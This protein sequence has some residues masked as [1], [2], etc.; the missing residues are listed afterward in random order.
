MRTIIKLLQKREI[1]TI[2]Q[3]RFLEKT[4]AKF[5]KHK[6][7]LAPPQG[8]K[9][10]VTKDIQIWSDPQT[11][12]IYEQQIKNWNEKQKSDMCP[13]GINEQQGK[14]IYYLKKGD[15]KVHYMSSKNGHSPELYLHCL[16][17][18]D[19]YI[20]IIHTGSIN[21]KGTYCINWSH[22]KFIE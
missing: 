15:Y 16:N 3:K 7:I 12:W 11:A 20:F 14:K 4:V 17:D 1:N 13:I 5:Q 10:K 22:I 21:N 2:L 19:K 9:I 18:S 8:C 6:T